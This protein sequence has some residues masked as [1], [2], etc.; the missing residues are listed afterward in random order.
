MFETSSFSKSSRIWNFRVE[1]FFLTDFQ[2]QPQAPPLLHP[3]LLT[4]DL[5]LQRDTARASI[6]DP[7]ERAELDGGLGSACR[8]RCG[9]GGCCCCSLRKR[10][11]RKRLHMSR[12]NWLQRV[13]RKVV[14]VFGQVKRCRQTWPP[15]RPPMV[16]QSSEISWPGDLRWRA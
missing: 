1:T 8:C 10:R 11:R 4:D 6:L 3:A 14:E 2:W 16:L 15:S 13:G 5:L 12:K 7:L 9:C